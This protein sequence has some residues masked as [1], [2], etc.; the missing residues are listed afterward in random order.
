MDFEVFG[1]TELEDM[2]QSMAEN[3]SEEQKEIFISQYGSMEEWKKNF[4]KKASGETAQK[5]FRKVVEWYGNKENALNA[6]TSPQGPEIF[7]AYQNRLETVLKKLSAKKGQDIHSFAVR[8][9]V[10]EYDF[11]T[12]QMYQLPDASA[13]MLELAA[14]YRNDPVIQDAQ[15]AVYGKG[16]TEFIGEAIEAFYHKAADTES[17][18]T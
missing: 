4:L 9:L 15:D 11:V 16:T 2:Y 3:M 14:S 6:A 5:N 18:L 12:K 8:E 7:A 10:G 1:Q 13:M 17:L